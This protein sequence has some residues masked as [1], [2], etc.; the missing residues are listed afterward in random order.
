MNARV[1]GKGWNSYVHANGGRFKINQPLFSH[2]TAQVADSEEK[3]CRLASEFGRV[4]ASRNLRVNLRK[5]KILRCSRYVNVGRMDV[6]QD[7]R[8][9]SEPL[10]EVD[11]TK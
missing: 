3:C 10:E 1:V 11:C 5:S 8:L 4:C 9:K 6:T 7:M 2:D